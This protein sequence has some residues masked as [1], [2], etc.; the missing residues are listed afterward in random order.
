M[1]KYSLHLVLWIH[2]K[3]D[4]GENPIYIKIT[5]DR[6][7]S[8]I[9]T[10]YHIL[11]KFWDK[12]N[13]LVK[14]TYKLHQHI[15]PGITN[16]KNQVSQKIVELQVAGKNSSAKEVKAIFSSGKNMLNFF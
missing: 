6:K 9:A 8:Y 15:N 7:T 3:N 16:K 12:K 1:K 13:E 11:P 2:H 14:N 10:G 4:R 5:I